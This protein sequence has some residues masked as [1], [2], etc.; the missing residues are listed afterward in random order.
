MIACLS[1]SGSEH[2]G[3]FF[4]RQSTD[5][6]TLGVGLFLNVGRILSIG[7]I[8]SIGCISS[9]DLKV[10]VFWDELNL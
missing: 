4:Q 7:R 8:S 10:V 5:E 2:K 3:G 9:I 1:S 6:V